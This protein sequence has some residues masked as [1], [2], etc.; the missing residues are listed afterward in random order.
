MTLGKKE[1]AIESWLLGYNTLPK[2][3]ETL[4]RIANY[5][6]LN[7]LNELSL[8]FIRRGIKIP[9]PNDLVLFIQYNVYSYLFIEE[10]S[11]IAY[12]TNL[13]KEGLL[14]CQYLILYLYEMHNTR[15]LALSNTLF[16]LQP[17]CKQKRAHNRFSFPTRD[18]FISSSSCLHLYKNQIN[19]IVRAVNYSMDQHFNYTSR[20]PEGIVQTINYWVE[21]DQKYNCNTFYE[22][23]WKTQPVPKHQTRVMGLEDVRFTFFNKKVY[24][25]AVDREHC[26]HSHPSILFLRLEKN[27]KNQYEIVSSA[28]IPYKNETTQKNWTIFCDKKLYLCYSHHP[29]TLLEVNPENGEYNVVVEKYSSLN[30]S[31]IRGSSNPIFIKEYNEWLFLVHEV[32]FQNTRKYYHRFIKYDTEWN[33]INVSEPFYFNELYVEFCLSIMYD[34]HK[35]IIPFS[36]KDNTTEIIRIEYS[37]ISWIPQNLSNYLKEI[38]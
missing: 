27:N 36:S 23:E 29:F 22:I 14:A 8:L 24:A 30:L 2:R 13:K 15:Q 3:S 21:M 10:L 1:L 33:L 20:H 26:E 35:I 32:G 6:R 34:K 16:Y 17:L 11:I 9:F 38:L 19:G 31:N 4:Y 25:I 18:P 28:P 5:Y 37:D 7:G 12:Y